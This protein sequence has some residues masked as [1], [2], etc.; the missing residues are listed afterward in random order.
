MM[1]RPRSKPAIAL[2]ALGLCFAVGSYIFAAMRCANFQCSLIDLGSF[3][4]IIAAIA[5]GGEPISTLQPPY[6]AQHWFGIHFSPIL[7][8][9]VPFYWLWPSP[10][11]LQALQSV[12]IASAC[13]PIFLSCQRLGLSARGSMWMGIVFLINPF[14]ISAAIW[15][16][17]EIAFAIP[18]FGW[19]FYA[20]IRKHFIGFTA[21]C[22][23][24]IITKE[25]YGLAVFGAGL[26]WT[27]EHQDKRKGLAL[28]AF[29]IAALLLITTVIMP[30]FAGGLVAAFDSGSLGNYR[31]GWITQSLSDMSVAINTL[32]TII[33]LG[34]IYLVM[35]LL[36]FV[37]LPLGTWWWLLPAGA[38][39]AANLLSSSILL[40][41]FLGYHSA[42]IIP[43]LAMAAAKVITSKNIPET[44][45]L[46]VLPLCYT[47][48]WLTYA[49]GPSYW[50]IKHAST[51]LAPENQAITARISDYVAQHP[52]A[53]VAVQNNLGAV[54]DIPPHRLT[55]F[56]HP[57]L[58]ADIIIA[59]IDFPFDHHIDRIGNVHNME[60]LAYLDKLEQMVVSGRYQP[61][62]YEQP[63]LLLARQEGNRQPGT[64]QSDILRAI[65]ELGEKLTDLDQ[66]S[67]FP[68]IFF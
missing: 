11:V 9:A 65:R 1:C 44:K 22:A 27:Y 66:Q 7:Y 45:R 3:Y 58:K 38:D 29:G 17:H 28:A 51:T 67:T 40:R 54:L 24:L 60:A 62:I 53:R 21:V 19:L 68:P 49:H 5:S 15:D 56:P 36:P 52:D 39:L 57:S 64:E 8:S 23:L 16:F 14:V 47:L 35:L 46:L 20:L 26:L 32:S 25:H 48:F 13:W 33:P 59:H 12:L 42:A 37:F 63:W 10:L 34:M 18:L 30:H 6:I 2:L 50:Q 31:Y 4:Q 61:V 41:S 43:I 55:Y